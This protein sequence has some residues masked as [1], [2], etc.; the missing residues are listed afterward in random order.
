MN[1]EK[2]FGIAWTVTILIF[3]SL[4]LIFILSHDYFYEMKQEKCERLKEIDY[5]IPSNVLSKCIGYEVNKF[6]N[7]SFLHY[8][9]GG[10]I[11]MIGVLI[12]GIPF[13]FWADDYY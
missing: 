12:I 8:F 13:F 7:Y 1:R 10:I 2:A 6:W 4:N 9:L 11:A 3:L 5:Q